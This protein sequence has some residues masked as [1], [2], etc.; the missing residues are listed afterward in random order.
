MDTAP[1]IMDGRT[2]LP[3]TY[4]AT[5]LGATLSWNQDQ[6]EVTITFNDEIINFWVGKNMA[7]VNSALTPIDP[8]NTGMVPIVVP[9]GRIMLPLAFIAEQL[10]CEISWDPTLQTVT[11]TYEESNNSNTSNA[12]PVQQPSQQP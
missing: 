10:G 8:D 12:E 3:M 2:L 9:P 11:V 1:I 5:P 7:D 4:V 6:Q